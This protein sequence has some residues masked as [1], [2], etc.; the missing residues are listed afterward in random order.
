MKAIVFVLAIAAFTAP[1]NLRAD[2]P[3]SVSL[4]NAVRQF[5]ERCERNGIGKDEQPLKPEAVVAAIRW[6]M[7]HREMLAVSDETLRVL[8]HIAEGGP[9]P[10]GYALEVLTGYEPNDEVTFNVWSVRLR[11]PGGSFPGGTT[12]I[13]IEEKM[14]NSRSIGP[15]E[16]KVI[17]EW[18]Q[19]E[20]E[21]GGIGSLERVR[22]MQN[23][24]AVR[25]A[26]A[27][28]D[29]KNRAGK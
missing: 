1:A 21:R 6:E 9:L 26:A 23:Y 17:R 22:W 20:R 28:V 14:V 19:K 12:C 13:T 25:E 24:R 7:L 16:R 10:N 5:N 27:A 11:V 8:G 29:E 4:A 2:G 15:E 18:R 3:E